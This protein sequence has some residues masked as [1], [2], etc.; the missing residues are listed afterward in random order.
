MPAEA[1]KASFAGPALSLLLHMAEAWFDRRD[2]IVFHDPLAAVLPFVPDVC[3]FERGVVTVDPNTGGT[4]F[5]RDEKGRDEV[6]LDANP[7]AFFAEFMGA[8]SH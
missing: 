3:R 7:E 8:F 6:A 2:E 5:V 4:A 1:V